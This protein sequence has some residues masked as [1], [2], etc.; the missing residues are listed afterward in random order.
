MTDITAL[1]LTDE[2]K[3]KEKEG[4]SQSFKLELT[5]SDDSRGER[6]AVATSSSQAREG[7][8]TP[9][10]VGRGVGTPRTGMDILIQL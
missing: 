6:A 2:K 8:G 4:G 5:I 10:N 3:V 1:R 9:S 7:E